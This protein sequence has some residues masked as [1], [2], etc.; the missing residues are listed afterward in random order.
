MAPDASHRMKISGNTML[1]GDLDVSGKYGCADKYTLA[2]VIANGNNGVTYNGNGATQTF[3]IS[4][5]HTAYSL[6]VFLNGVAQVPGVDYT[7]TGNAV[8]FSIS[9]PPG[10]GD[11][12][13]IRE[14]VI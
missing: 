4:P 11:T 1:D 9:S 14:L 5:G 8:D 3:N 12:I 2:T 13:Q 6:L 7:V 10:T